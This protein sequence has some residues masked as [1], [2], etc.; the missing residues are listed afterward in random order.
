MI[1]TYAWSLALAVSFLASHDSAFAEDG[2]AARQRRRRRLGRRPRRARGE[3]TSEETV[4]TRARE[5]KG[6]S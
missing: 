3:P 4:W 6:T 1:D 2:S 5:A